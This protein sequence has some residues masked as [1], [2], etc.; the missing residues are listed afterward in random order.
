M[1]IVVANRVLEVVVVDPAKLGGNR[2]LD[3]LARNNR[4]E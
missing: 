4:A 1:E 2:T 3:V